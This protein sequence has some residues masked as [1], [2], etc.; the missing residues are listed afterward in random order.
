MNK[1][2]GGYQGPILSHQYFGWGTAA[3]LIVGLL[4]WRRD[5]RLWLF[6]AVTVASGLLA[7]GQQH[8]TW[9]PWQALSTVPLFEN[10]IPSRFLV[11]TYLAVAVMVALIVDHAHHAAADSLSRRRLERGA[12]W[13]A[14]AVGI[15]VAAVALVP[16]VDYLVPSLPFTTQAV[17]LPTWFSSA[18]PHLARHRQ[19]VLVFPAP[20][21]LSQSALTWQ[22]VDHDA[23][24]V[25][26]QG[27]PGGLPS[28]AG[29]E[30][31]GLAVISDASVDFQ[32]QTIGPDSIVAVR[33]ALDGW[34]VTTVVIPDQ[35]SLPTYDQI[36]SVTKA[37][38][39]MAAAT[40]QL[41]AHQ[42][43]AWVWTG[44][45]H[46]GPPVAV[47]SQRFTECTTGLADH[48]NS[49]VHRATTCVLASP[50]P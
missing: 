24:S 1:I 35:P 18:V 21:S 12:G 29:G 17:T 4:L 48:G 45:R 47:S 9:L 43:N 3:V 26:G 5:L 42:A 22:A 15:A 38:A 16:I 13:W 28:R 50:Q 49:A 31:A 36:D 34:G 37:A 33:H 19:V 14:G 41:P 8:G 10:V 32:G 23:F 46:S 27:G 2:V 25:A 40:G 6:G 11:E 44:V 30:A 20:F 39:L 7:L